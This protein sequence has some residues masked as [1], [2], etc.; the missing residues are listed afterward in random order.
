MAMRHTDQ[1]GQLYVELTTQKCELP[2]DEL[3][4]LQEPLDRIAEAVAGVPAKL[5]IDIV[6]HPPRERY[7]AEAA[8]ELPG[9]TL[10]SG[11]WDAYLDSELEQSLVKLTRKAKIYRREPAPKEVGI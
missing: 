5:E 8:L 9:R 11:Q 2:S 3:T 1:R 10:F 6:C 7:H 4:R